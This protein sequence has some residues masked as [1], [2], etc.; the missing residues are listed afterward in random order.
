LNTLTELRSGDLAKSKKL[1]LA[2]GLTSFPKEI[3]TLADT[4]EYLDMTDNKLSSL[5]DDFGKL[6]N[7]KILFLSNNLFTKLPTILAECPKLS[8]IGFRNNQINTV[9]EDA[10]P[11]STRWLILTDNELTILPDSIGNLAHL[12]KCMLSGNQLTSLPQ[13]MKKCHNLELLRIAVNQLTEL[14]SWLLQLPKLSWLAY[15]GNP[16]CAKHPNCNIPLKEI[17]WEKLEI[18]EILGEGASGLIFKAIANGKEVAIKV[19]KGDITSDGLPQEEIDINI[20]MGHHDHLVDVLAK[21]V[22]HPEGKDVLMLELIP[23]TFS[24]LGLPPTLETCT[25][26]VYSEGLKLS[27]SKGIKILQGIASASLH[28]HQ[29][30]IMHGDLYAHNIMIDSDGNSILGDFGGASYFE[31]QAV[32]VRNALERLEV[33]ALG[34]LIEEIL[35]LCKNDDSFH[36]LKVKLEQLKNICLNTINAQRPL[37]ETIFKEINHLYQISNVLK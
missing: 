5:P 26:D 8:M 34:C 16:F 11:R 19:F 31:P 30:G 33:R 15:S 7:L 1:K 37:F 29:R 25:R 23:S 14:P 18:K 4:L 27:F 6:K 9:A 13:S 12:Q 17:T 3:Y 10:L 32:E 36:E 21:V 28:M 20:S 24:N 35:V 22:T 2:E